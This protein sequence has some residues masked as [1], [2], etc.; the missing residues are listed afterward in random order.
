MKQRLEEVVNNLK[1]EE[2]KLSDLLTGEEEFYIQSY[3]CG[4]TD[5]SIT[6]RIFYLGKKRAL[7]EA[8]KEIEA[9]TKNE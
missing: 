6:C 9:L 5:R 4:T 3:M 8:L 2:E 7:E 1:K